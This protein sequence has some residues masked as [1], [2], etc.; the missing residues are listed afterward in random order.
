MFAVRFGYENVERHAVDHVDGGR[1]RCPS[2]RHLLAFLVATRALMY[3]SRNG[4]LPVK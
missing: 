4:T 3:T 2:T 1:A